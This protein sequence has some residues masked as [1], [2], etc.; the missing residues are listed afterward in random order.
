[1]RAWP[2]K[3]KRISVKWDIPSFCR[4]SSGTTTSTALPRRSQTRRPSLQAIEA[5]ISS[6]ARVQ[7]QQRDLMRPSP[8]FLPWDAQ[9]EAVGQ[10]SRLLRTRPRDLRAVVDVDACRDGAKK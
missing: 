9:N 6:C 10:A 4:L 5:S 3:T 2:A 7:S 8:L 1:M